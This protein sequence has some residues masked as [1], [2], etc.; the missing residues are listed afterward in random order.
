MQLAATVMSAIFAGL[1]AMLVFLPDTVLSVVRDLNTPNGL[2]VAAGVRLLFGGLLLTAASTSRAPNLLR[3]FGALIF[4]AGIA[5]PMF[6]TDRARNVI[7]ALA[8]DKGAYARMAGTLAI[9]LGC[10]FVFALSPRS[11]QRPR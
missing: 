1:G 11:G 6:G 8:A 3:V 10:A 5:T 4:L 7:D 2:F 9:A